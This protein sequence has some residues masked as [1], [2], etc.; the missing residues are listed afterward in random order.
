M[1][2]SLRANPTRCWGVDHREPGC[3]WGLTKQVGGP[4][5]GSAGQMWEEW[6]PGGLDELIFMLPGDGKGI[7][8]KRLALV[9]VIAILMGLV[10]FASPAF[11]A[12]W[13]Q[14]PSPSSPTGEQLQGVAATSTT[15]AWAV[16]VSFGSALNDQSPLI[17]HWNGN[18]WR[19]VRGPVVNGE[20]RAVRAV[21][22]SNVWAVGDKRSS[23]DGSITSSLIEHY[24]GSSW[25]KVA[26]P[27]MDRLNAVA[28]PSSS[29][30][31]AVG[32]KGLIEHWNG[33]RWRQ[34]HAN[35]SENLYGISMASSRN[36]WAVGRNVILHWDGESWKVVPYPRDPWGGGD[37]IRAVKVV[38]ATNVY[39]VGQNDT[40]PSP[41]ILHYN[42]T[43]WKRLTSTYGCCTYDDLYSLVALSPSNVWA[44][45]TNEPPS[46]ITYGVTF[47]WNGTP[48]M[49][50][51]P[52]CDASSGWTRGTIPCT[53]DDGSTGYD[54]H[55]AARIPGTKSF[56]AVGFYDANG[57]I[58]D[59]LPN[60]L[61]SRHG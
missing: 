60:A 33:R 20:L 9:S 4:H 44:V 45:G 11:A 28:S 42:G 55:S 25:S 54:Y 10:P 34:K 7:G 58:G 48:C 12:G 13:T 24:N 52:F 19:R 22:R 5:A 32:D 1:L 16:G 38:S 2:P 30:A 14:F 40:D 57:G 23:L 51:S 26:S 43:K 53:C 18:A 35:T 29:E 3:V 56:W 15:N 21:G 59:Y 61:I 41:L 37:T 17:E 31:W 49:A 8:M 36:G 46:T 50:G 39:A 6:A 47:H 27:G